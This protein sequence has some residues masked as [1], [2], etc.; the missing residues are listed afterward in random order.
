MQPATVTSHAWAPSEYRSDSV[1]RYS[2]HAWGV[3][4]KPLP[5]WPETSRT[6]PVTRGGVWARGAALRQDDAAKKTHTMEKKHGVWRRGV[7]LALVIRSDAP[8]LKAGRS[9][10]TCLEEKMPACARASLPG[11]CPKY[12]DH[13]TSSLG[14]EN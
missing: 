2:S 11:A 8:S 13:L 14:K 9:N 10:K 12:H 1:S 3:H 5:A 6:L 7:A 4:P